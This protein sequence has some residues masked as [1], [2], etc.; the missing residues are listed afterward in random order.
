MLQPIE[1][2]KKALLF[3]ISFQIFIIAIS[4]Y[5]V[6]IPL[7]AFGFTTTWGALTFPFIF[8]ATDLTV[9]IFGRELARKIIFFTMIPALLISYYFS[10]VFYE[11]RFV[12]HSGL[13]EFNLFV[14]RIVVA[15][16][17]AY[18]VGQLLDIY[19]FNYLRQVKSWWV[20]PLASTFVGSLIDSLCF[21]FIAFYKS[22]D[23]FMAANWI[24]IGTIDYLFKMVMG[25]FVFLPAYG[26]LL[27]WLQNMLTKPSNS[28]ASKL[29][30][31][32]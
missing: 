11:G 1:Y 3:L 14:F 19:V 26:V 28:Q 8:L 24:E 12:G 32:N 23:A 31:Q 16:F 21:F 29:V 10:V 20:A 18:V 15:S 7:Q 17:C 5:L 27:S 22:P 30:S 25:I 6:Q 13:L 2:T 4:N 9:R